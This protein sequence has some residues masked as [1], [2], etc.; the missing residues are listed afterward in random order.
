MRIAV[1]SD[2][3]SNIEAL[4]AVLLH[5]ERGG[6]IDALWCAGDIVG[7]G[8]DPDTVIAVLRAR[9]VQTVAG[10]HDLAACGMMTTEEF[11]PVAE[12]AARWT[13][14][15]LSADSLAYLGE[16]PL[17][18]K[19]SAGVTI[20][21]GSLR[22]PEWEYLLSEEQADA[23]FALQETQISIVGHSHLQFWSRERQGGSPLFAAKGGETIELGDGRYILNPGSS[24][25][26]RDGDPRAGYMLYDDGAATVTWQR[27]EYDA[28]VTC[29]RIIAEGLPEF[30]GT[31]LLA[32]R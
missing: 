5:A 8:P 7:Y 18:L 2:V 13:Q 25:Q 3:H 22:H 23:Q 32:G 6:A 28:N 12:E 17:V 16:L 9:S 27:V 11:N 14:E 24:G 30:L 20:V 21:H 15:H 1:V 31:R 26:P 29:A 4:D 10:N 19:P